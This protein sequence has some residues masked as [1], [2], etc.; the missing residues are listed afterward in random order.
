MLPLFKT[1]FL[2]AAVC[3]SANTMVLCFESCHSQKQVLST[4]ADKCLL[5]KGL[6]AQVQHHEL[7]Q[8]LVS[9]VCSQQAEMDYADRPT[10]T[11]TS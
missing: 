11:C 7:Q 4:T 5:S 3:H 8:L 10:L 6:T 2:P 1:A 9:H